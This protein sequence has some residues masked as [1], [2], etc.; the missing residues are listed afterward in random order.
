MNTK[1]EYGIWTPTAMVI[2]Y[3]CH[4]EKFDWSGKRAI[5][6]KHEAEPVQEHNGVTHCDYCGKDIQVYDEIAGEHNLVKRL[7]EAG[8]E[9]AIMDQTGGM[10]SACTIPLEV[11][12]EGCYVRWI[13]I[14]YGME[15]YEDTNYYPCI[16][17]DNGDYD[18]LGEWASEDLD[19]MIEMLKTKLA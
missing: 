10:N 13:S 3:D 8:V 6:T 16:M 5:I 4:E 9:Q 1:Y 15:S 18:D 11:D 2:C 19:E 7:N 17:D 12:G 14:K